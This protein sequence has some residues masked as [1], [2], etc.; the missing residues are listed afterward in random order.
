MRHLIVVV[1]LTT[2]VLS[3]V[4]AEATGGRLEAQKS[5]IERGARI[6]KAFPTVAKNQTRPQRFQTESPEPEIPLPPDGG[7]NSASCVKKHKCSGGSI[8][9]T[10]DCNADETANGCGY[11]TGFKCKG[12]NCN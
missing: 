6:S 9:A 3:A 11:C 1:V 8:C 12:M 2:V 7:G 5:S 10:G 4:A